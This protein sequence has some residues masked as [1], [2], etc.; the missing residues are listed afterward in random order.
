MFSVV[1]PLYNSSKTI[2]LVID[3]LIKE[4]SLLGI[5]EYEI[6]LV[7]DGSKDNVLDI[8]KNLANNNKKI[9]VIDLA[10]NS[11]QTNAMIA[12]Y[13]NASGE[14]I[15]NMDDDM[16]TPG[17]EIGKLISALEENDLDVVFA[18]YITHQESK[19]RLF[20]SYLN[21][22]MAEIMVGKP[23]DLK[24]NSFFIMKKYVANE[25]VK[26]KNNYPYI[27]GIILAITDKVGNVKVNH[28]KRENGESNHT[29]K[30]LVSLWLN[31]FLNFSIKPLRIATA[32]GFII[33][34]ISAIVGIVLFINRL[35]NPGGV[36]G[37]TSLILAIIFFAGLQLVG[38]GILGEY[39]G[40]L[41]ISSSDLPTYVIRDKVNF[42]QYCKESEVDTDD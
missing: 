41:Y 28:R 4:F 3:E 24:T 38:I 8:A 27:Y 33:S 19:F 15:I 25:I 32:S 30:K 31:G 34:V 5:F 1:I 22:K 14:Y 21:Q 23:K 26:Y 36:L 29:L 2:E 10:K 18:D 39:L 9:K 16:Q 11:G 6:V 35:V 7:N 42:E 20:G 37:W 17:N 13:Q 40:R 12:G